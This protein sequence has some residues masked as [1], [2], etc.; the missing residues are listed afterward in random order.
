MSA[1]VLTQYDGMIL[2]P[3]AKVLGYIMNAI[4][5]FL[6]V[7]GI[8]NI[9]LSIILF[10]VVVN[11]LMIPLTIKQQ[12]FQ[13]LSA[14]MNPEIQA[15]QKKYG[16]KKDTVSMQKMQDEMNLVYEKYGTSPTGG[17]LP[18]LIQMPILFALFRVINNIPA[19]ITSIKEMFTGLVAG[20]TNVS[21]FQEIMQTFISDNKIQ[22]KL[23]F[24]TA[25]TTRNTLI[26]AFYLFKDSDWTKFEELSQFSGLNPQIAELRANLSHVSNFLGLNLTQTPWDLV[27]GVFV[28]GSILLAIGALMIPVLSAVTQWLNTKLMPQ[29]ASANSDDPSAN[30]MKSMNTTMPLMSAFFC[31]TFQIGLGIY[32]IASSAVRCIIQIIMNKWF[33]NIDVDDIIA[34]NTAK[35]EKRKEKEGYSKNQITKVANKN[36]RNINEPSVVSRISEENERA[37]QEAYKKEVKEGSIAD[38]ARMVQR[39]NEKNKK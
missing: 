34:K 11:V 4:Y 22:A 7:V 2:G 23:D 9:G 19:Y 1:Y 30:M 6:D 33:S 21:G 18:L 39:Y 16:N 12:K 27:K 26:D 15:I 3:I 17:C 8:P 10:T 31:F 14:K 38:R 28:G 5:N 20:V 13:K 24:A 32:W 37:L 35:A 29:A 36:A 25:E